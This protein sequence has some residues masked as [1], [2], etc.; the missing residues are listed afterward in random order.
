MTHASVG[1]RVS[2]YTE[3]LHLHVQEGLSDLRRHCTSRQ[4]AKTRLCAAPVELL[5]DDLP[6]PQT[7]MDRGAKVKTEVD[8]CGSVRCRQTVKLLIWLIPRQVTGAAPG[9]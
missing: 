2:S 4:G 3:C 6:A 9:P 8:D 7:V 1:S 5:L